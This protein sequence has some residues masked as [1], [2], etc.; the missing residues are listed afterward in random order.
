MVRQSVTVLAASAALSAGIGFTLGQASAPEPAEAQ[1]S[2]RA[3]V[4]ELQRMNRSLT[5]I[6]G[7]LDG[8]AGGKDARQLLQQICLNSA[9]A[10]SGSRCF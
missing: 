1:A 7:S 10:T 4:R 6:R 8:V 2:N 3:V 9:D 5:A